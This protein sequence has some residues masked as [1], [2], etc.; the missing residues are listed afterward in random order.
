MTTTVLIGTQ[1]NKVVKLMT[2]S[3]E[4]LL[5]PGRWLTV[6]IHGDQSVT[7]QETGEFVNPP[8]GWAYVAKD[9]A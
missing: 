9:T 3:G 5:Q 8:P 6:G 4:M 7:V 2:P 1:G